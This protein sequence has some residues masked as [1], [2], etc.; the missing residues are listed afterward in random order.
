[1]NSAVS[2]QEQWQQHV[3]GAVRK[4]LKT[5]V[6]IDNQPSIEAQLVASAPPAEA[7][8]MGDD[9]GALE[10]PTNVTRNP[11]TNDLNIRNVTDAFISQGI[12]CALVLPD[13][14]DTDD[15]SKITRSLN[16]AKV[17][18]LV[19]IDWYLNKQDSS[20]TLR[21]L[22]E[23]ARSDCEEKGRL[24]LV[25]VYTSESLT[26]HIFDAV[27]KQFSDAGIAL[28]PVTGESYC[29]IANST[30]VLLAN[31]N[32]TPVRELPN[33][34]V[35]QFTKLTNGLIP[36]FA[37]AAVGAI[38]KNTH[39]MLT[40]FH[41]S[42]DSAYVSNRLITNPP[43]D[44]AELM[45]E[46]LVAECD[47]A[48][49]LDSIADDYLEEE[50][51][52]SWLNSIETKITPCSYEEK[53]GG[54]KQ[55][56]T[57]DMAHLKGLL[58]WGVGDRDFTLNGTDRIPF[59]EFKRSKVSETLAGGKIN[60]QAS[61]NEFSKLVVLRREAYGPSTH[62]LNPD[63]RPSL[64]TGS[65]LKFS[66]GDVEKYLMCFTP[67]CDALR[68]DNARPFVFL[69]GRRSA[70]KYNMVITESNGSPVGVQFE[71]KYPIVRTF[72][73]KPD[74]KTQR[75]RADLS[76]K[77]FLFNGFIGEQ[78]AVFEWMG[79]VRYA[80]ATS[81]MAGLSSV[82]MRIGIVDSEYLRLA[83]KGHVKFS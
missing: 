81:E 17:S 52:T 29:A 54:A 27:T 45:R 67:A 7:T 18:D 33:L 46:L 4:F 70:D 20:L 60:S 40:R 79:E 69:E 26:S 22:D 49:G 41:S 6:V 51:I 83:S 63:W 57:L 53:I 31:K 80:R 8:G 37:L 15:Q 24:R 47:N 66:E 39:H 21:I 65:V 75:V 12:A 72:D 74:V 50:A 9:A 62:L 55:N 19:V 78:Q 73:F 3:Q 14:K 56:I 28:T 43:G 35:T 32:E 23:I 38:R 77:K 30:L 61:Q 76:D 59:P 13:D 71:K 16:A 36:A 5:A 11:S 2:P 10:T 44:V 82:W 42:L 48:L 34:L 25:C 68:I 1:M 58:S 64:T